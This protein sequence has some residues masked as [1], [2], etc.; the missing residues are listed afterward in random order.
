MKTF[1]FYINENTHQVLP[2]NEYWEIL[3]ADD[4]FIPLDVCVEEDGT[5][6]Y[7]PY[8]VEYDEYGFPY[9]PEYT[10]LEYT[11]DQ[12]YASMIESYIENWLKEKSDLRLFFL[13]RD[14][15]GDIK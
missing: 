2:E 3:E 8:R 5:I 14:S 1:T 12:P 11:F 13:F 6:I 7:K 10:S 4:D 15:G 9:Y